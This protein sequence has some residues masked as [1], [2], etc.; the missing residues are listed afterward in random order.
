MESGCAGRAGRRSP[1]VRRGAALTALLAATA[2]PV[3]CGGGGSADPVAHR[4]APVRCKPTEASKPFSGRYGY[5]APNQ[6]VDRG[7]KL[8]AMVM[9]NC[10]AFRIALD[11]ERAPKT[12]NSF[13][14]LARVGFYEH[15]PFDR[16]TPGH[17]IQAGD[18]RGSGDS[19]SGPGYSTEERP[20]TDL[21]YTKGTVAMAK[22]RS[23]P[24]GFSRSQFF[25]VLAP[26]A[27]L[28]PEY[29][30]IGKVDRGM[31]VVE[32]IGEFGTPAGKP[33]KTVTIEWIWA[34]KPSR[35][36]EES[37]AV[38]VPPSLLK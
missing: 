34:K 17:T 11:T 9:T 24:S 14:H 1:R 20:P 36:E 33:T 16:V 26:D 7:E 13:A 2:L 15:M 29:A 28:P 31:E 38:Q 18:P 8:V 3:G 27:K 37:Q 25:I 19:S 12:V 6:V 22:R 21:T 30:L 35:K 32:R 4:S 5:H 23:D 10:G